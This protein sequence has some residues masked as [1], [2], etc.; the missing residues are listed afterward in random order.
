MGMGTKRGSVRQAMARSAL[1][2]SRLRLERREARG[3][4][5]DL[6]I[7]ARHDVAFASTF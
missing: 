3:E 5:R 1:G 4:R 6:V 2:R 7:H